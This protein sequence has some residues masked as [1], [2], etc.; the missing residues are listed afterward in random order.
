MS[1]P[2]RH[3]GYYRCN[4]ARSLPGILD[5]VRYD[6]DTAKMSKSENE[7]RSF[8]TAVYIEGQRLVEINNIPAGNIKV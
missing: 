1:D 2:L 7:N 8:A 4:F 3:V 5:V 6:T